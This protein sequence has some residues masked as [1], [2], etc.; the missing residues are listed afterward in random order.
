MKFIIPNTKYKTLYSKHLLN[1][2][3]TERSLDVPF[4]FSF[5]E[6]FFVA[7]NSRLGNEKYSKIWIVS[8]FFLPTD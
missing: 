1:I 3:Y 5:N 4:I 8:F 6:M 7:Y 2:T